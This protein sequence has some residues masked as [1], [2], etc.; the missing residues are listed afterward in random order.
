MMRLPCFV[1]PE[2]AAR[3]AFP[4]ILELLSWVFAG[5]RSRFVQIMN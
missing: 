1:V 5:E 3:G 2:L 4:C